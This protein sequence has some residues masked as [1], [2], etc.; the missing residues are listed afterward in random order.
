MMEARVFL[1]P[2]ISADRTKLGS[3]P[4]SF[5]FRKDPC[6][7]KIPVTQTLSADFRTRF[8]SSKS[9]VTKMHGGGGT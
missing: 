7:T 1:K 9:D 6:L 2:T 4:H 5:L 8:P 3:S